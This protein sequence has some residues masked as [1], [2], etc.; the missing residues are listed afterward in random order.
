MI[1]CSICPR[2]ITELESHNAQP[3]NNGRCC[4]ECNAKFVIPARLNRHSQRAITETTRV[5]RNWL[6]APNPFK[7]EKPQGSSLHHM[8]QFFL[9]HEGEKIAEKIREDGHVLQ[10]FVVEHDWGAVLGDELGEF[11]LPYP[12]CSFEFRISGMRCIFMFNYIDRVISYASFVG[13][14]GG[15]VPF[16]TCE[17]D[18]TGRLSKIGTLEH[19]G[20]RPRLISSFYEFIFRQIRA[21][22]VMF[23]TSVAVKQTVRAPEKLNRQRE[24]R[25]RTK[26]RDYHVVVLNRKPRVDT[27]PAELQTHGERNSPRLHFRRGHWRHMISHRTWINWQLVGNPDL[28]FVDKH[29]RLS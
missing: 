15:W 28:G 9:D 1:R 10:S 19:L 29:Y 21:V 26:L 6:E 18:S 25:G 16:P 7:L 2:H 14:E 20:I 22:C 5:I 13:Y 27:V 8:E 24:K 3:I 4:A 23:E 17:F 12:F 11:I